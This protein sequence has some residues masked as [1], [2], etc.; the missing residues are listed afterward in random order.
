MT[1]IVPFSDNWNKSSHALKKKDFGKWELFLPKNSDGTQQI[2]H[3][4]KYK[5]RSEIQKA[6]QHK[7]IFR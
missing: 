1:Q 7:E 6:H 4:S 5:V 3:M 2:G